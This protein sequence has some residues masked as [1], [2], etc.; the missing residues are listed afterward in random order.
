MGN[1][2]GI[3]PARSYADQKLHDLYKKIKEMEERIIALEVKGATYANG[4]Y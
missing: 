4:R 3:F 1:D 2:K